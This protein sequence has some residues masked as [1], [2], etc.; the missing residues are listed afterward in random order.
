[1]PKTKRDEPAELLRL[2]LTDFDA[3]IAKLQEARA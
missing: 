1:M 2:A 3:Q